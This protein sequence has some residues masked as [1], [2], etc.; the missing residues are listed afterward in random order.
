MDQ[1]EQPHREV[2]LLAPSARTR[3][4]AGAWASTEEPG[5]TEH[6][7]RWRVYSQVRRRRG[8]SSAEG[9]GHHRPRIEHDLPG[10]R[11]RRRPRPAASA[12]RPRRS[13][14]RT[15]SPAPRSAAESTGTPPRTARPPAS[16]RRH[17]PPT[18]DQHRETSGRAADHDVRRRTTLQTQRV[19]EDV[20]HDR[21]VGQAGRQPVDGER[22]TEA[23]AAA[24]SAIPNRS[25]ATGGTLLAGHR[26]SL[27]PRH[28]RVDVAVDHTVQ[29]VGAARSQSSADQ[30]G[31][32]GPQMRQ[33]A[34]GEDHH[35]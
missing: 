21:A 10:H 16:R 8:A 15:T 3:A 22:P 30:R 11:A 7:R 23:V 1:V 26:P 28:H 29:C 31:G 17:A 19:D 35:G 6:R 13:H 24:P 32:R 5:R 27:R 14:P 4:I 9:R 2:G 34:G 20:E 18:T 25:A 12:P 33:S